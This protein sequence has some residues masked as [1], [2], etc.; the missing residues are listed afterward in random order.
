MAWMSLMR[1]LM[2][3]TVILST[4]F[5]S[6]K[7][8]PGQKFVSAAAH[9]SHN[10]ITLYVHDK[11]GASRAYRELRDAIPDEAEALVFGIVNKAEGVLLWVS[12]TTKALLMGL[13]E[14]DGL[15][16]LNSVL[17]ELSSDLEVLYTQLWRRI[18]LERR[19]DGACL[20]LLFLAYEWAPSISKN[21]ESLDPETLWLL[22]DEAL[23]P[24]AP[25]KFLISSFERRLDSRT[26]GLLTIKN[27]EL[28][29]YLHRTARDWI[30]SMVP[31]INSIVPVNFD[32]HLRV[33]QVGMRNDRVL[34]RTPLSMRDWRA[35]SFFE[36]F[37]KLLRYASALH[38]VQA[39][40]P[41]IIEAV[42]G[43]A[44]ILR[45]E[46]MLEEKEVWAQANEPQAEH[47]AS[48]MPITTSHAYSESQQDQAF[49]PPVKDH[50]HFV[51]LAA[52][53]NTNSQFWIPAHME[54]RSKIPVSSE[55]ERYILNY[56]FS[57]T[58]MKDPRYRY[59]FMNNL[60]T[61]DPFRTIIT[62]NSSCE[63]RLTELYDELL[64]YQ[65]RGW[66]FECM[67]DLPITIQGSDGTHQ[68]T[69]MDFGSAVIELLK[70]HG[71]K[72][73]LWGSAMTVL[74]LPTRRQLK[75]DSWKV[76]MLDSEYNCMGFSML[77]IRT[78]EDGKRLLCAGHLV[79]GNKNLWD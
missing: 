6:Y 58:F 59:Q 19:Q 12:L 26:R 1:P 28:V 68:P 17:G 24:Q 18:P 69:T 61:R 35:D 2:V 38:D 31:E 3:A 67:L 4:L 44:D 51:A 74:P 71:I 25:H 41:Q 57:F 72:L 39:H 55:F 60:L 27:G 21:K 47:P 42:D 40:Y 73:S 33:L 49:W 5:S 48:S 64:M 20:I 78:N 32:P 79:N 43:L 62:G 10:D 22:A 15:S 13:A 9:G 16:K 29:D 54:D 34:D 45:R 37:P 7:H 14:G 75:D 30:E 23:E 52:S 46:Y 56:A 65:K 77:P 50:I 53:W 8:F 11:F 70:M 76:R 63:K 36:E 66:H